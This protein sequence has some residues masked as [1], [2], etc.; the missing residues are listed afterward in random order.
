MFLVLWP[1]EGPLYQPLRTDEYGMKTDMENGY[2]VSIRHY[3]DHKCH[4]DYPGVE[5]G[6]PP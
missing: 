4:I 1:P 5:N 2:K 6:P 3:V